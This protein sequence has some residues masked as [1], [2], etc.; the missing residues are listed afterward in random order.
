MTDRKAELKS[1]LNES[2]RILN[3]VF[4]QVGDRWEMQVY[5]D[6]LGWTVKQIAAHLVDAERGHLTQASNIAE[7]RDIIP[8][9]FDIERYNKSRTEKNTD[10]TVEQSRAELEDVRNEIFSW[11]DGLDEE[12]LDRKGRH[13]SLQIMTVHDIMR[14]LSLHERGHAADIARALDIKLK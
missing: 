6:G 3:S 12:K 2:R 9:N 1:K 4:D 11:L 8:E 13:A 10:K 5:S 14:L 7:G